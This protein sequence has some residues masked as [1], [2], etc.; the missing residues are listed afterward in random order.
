MKNT[1]HNH[2]LSFSGFNATFSNI[3]TDTYGVSCRWFNGFTLPKSQL[4]IVDLQ[5]LMRHSRSIV[6]ADSY[7]GWQKMT[8][9]VQ[10]LRFQI[11]PMLLG[12]NA[13][14]MNAANVLS[15][16]VAVH[17]RSYHLYF[18]CRTRL[19][20]S[21][22]CH[23]GSKAAKGP[24]SKYSYLTNTTLCLIYPDADHSFQ[25]HDTWSTCCEEYDEQKARG[26]PLIDRFKI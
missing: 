20:P 1:N 17:N 25:R 26:A 8:M 15:L 24:S 2:K 11:C 13:Q 12:W 9:S 5:T 10:S 22:C 23:P 14:S 7:T 3:S 18:P 16:L 4:W 6:V 19:V 21:T